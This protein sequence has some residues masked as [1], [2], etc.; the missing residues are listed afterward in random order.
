MVPSVL[1]FWVIAQLAILEGLTR[2]DAEDRH[3]PI[4]E[5]LAGKAALGG[6]GRGDG[7]C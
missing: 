5:K 1:E 4:R 6:L 2:F 7:P 3:G